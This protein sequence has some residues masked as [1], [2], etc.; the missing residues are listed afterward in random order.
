MYIYVHRCAPN[1]VNNYR[2]I[3]N[4]CVPS[5]DGCTWGRVVGMNSRQPHTKVHKR[6]TTGG[7]PLMIKT[8][9]MVPG[10]F[11]VG[12][13]S[14]SPQHKAYPPPPQNHVLLEVPCHILMEMCPQKP[15]SFGFGSESLHNPQI[16]DLAPTGLTIQ[17][18]L[19]KRFYP[20][21]GG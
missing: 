2:G 21:T 6:P 7:N 5:D 10:G 15:L 12:M 19:Q 20:G 3:S 8:Q 14:R 16:W 13:F 18:G 17:G 1:R 11:A 9:I 4:H